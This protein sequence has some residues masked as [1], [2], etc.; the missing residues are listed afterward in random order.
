M[1]DP[2]LTESQVEL[3]KLN[4]ARFSSSH[5]KFDVWSKPYSN[6]YE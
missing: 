4:S 5:V 1:D 3:F 6:N 2:N